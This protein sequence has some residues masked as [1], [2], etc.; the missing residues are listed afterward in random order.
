ML[1]EEIVEVEFSKETKINIGELSYFLYNLK[2]LYTLL[3]KSKDLEEFM[4]EVTTP[5]EILHI[6]KRIQMRITEHPEILYDLRIP[7]KRYSLFREDLK[8]RNIFI[9]KIH[10][11]SP[12]IVWFMGITTLIVAALLISGGEAEFSLIPPKI[13]VKINSLGEGI[14]KLREA[15]RR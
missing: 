2:I 5:E 13:R 8:E 10:K 1:Y 4:I 6:A 11:E 7:Y 12:L 9:V 3:A 15:L 14:R